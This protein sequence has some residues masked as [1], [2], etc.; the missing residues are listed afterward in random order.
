MSFATSSTA[1]LEAFESQPLNSATF[2]S[3]PLPPSP[4]RIT[5]EYKNIFIFLISYYFERQKRNTDDN[6][7]TVLLSVNKLTYIQ[8]FKT[9]KTRSTV[10]LGKKT[11]RTVGLG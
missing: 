8:A 10:G 2:F 11:Y 3:L 4:L 5:S 6:M 1:S 7:V 9:D